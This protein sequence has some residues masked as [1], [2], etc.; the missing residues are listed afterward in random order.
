VHEYIDMPGMIGF[1]NVYIRMTYLDTAH[2]DL[3]VHNVL[4]IR[5]NLP[6]LSQLDNGDF[7]YT[8]RRTQTD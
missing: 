7:K 8:N 5:V 4:L 3:V 1:V 2:L 6:V